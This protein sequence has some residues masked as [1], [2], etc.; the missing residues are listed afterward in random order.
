MHLPRIVVLV[1]DCIIQRDSSQIIL[2]KDTKDLNVVVQ[3]KSHCLGEW[4]KIGKRGSPND[5][6][7]MVG[8]KVVQKCNTTM[9]GWFK[10][11]H[12]QIR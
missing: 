10:G 12:Q 4:I 9:P 3:D 6:L 8:V 7:H 1:A 2:Y 11:M 5:S